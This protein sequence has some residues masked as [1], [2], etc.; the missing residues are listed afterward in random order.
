MFLGSK[1]ITL[2]GKRRGRGVFPVCSSFLNHDARGLKEK[3]RQRPKKEN[4]ENQGQAASDRVRDKTTMEDIILYDAW[5]E[6]TNDACSN[7]LK[8]VQL[9]FR[10]QQLTWT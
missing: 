3:Q 7:A 10:N 6:W 5:T 2:K 8:T 1:P 9:H 4:K